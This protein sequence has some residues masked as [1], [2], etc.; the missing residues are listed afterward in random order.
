[1][2]ITNKKFDNLVKAKDTLRNELNNKAGI[3]K[4]INDKNGNYYVGSSNNLYRRLSEHCNLDRTKKLLKKGQSAIGS[5]IMRY[6]PENFSL[7]ILELI[8]LKKADT[9]ED[10]KLKI[11][12]REQFYLDLLNPEYNINLIAGSNLGRVYS[13]EVRSKMSKAKKGLSSHRKGKTHLAESRALMV[14]NNTMKKM[15]HTYDAD[16][17][18]LKSYPSILAAQAAT[19]IP[20]KRIQKSA[21]QT[22]AI[23]LKENIIFSFLKLDTLTDF[24]KLNKNI[25]NKKKLYVYNA[26]GS[27][28]KIFD[29]ITEGV[30]ETNVSAKRI[31]AYAKQLGLIKKP[32]FILDDKFIF[33]FEPLKK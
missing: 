19:G 2:N 20:R 32:Q 11:L 3:Y 17:K 28:F 27:L 21:I 25:S 7:V 16:G 30:K 22:P 13:D 23:L 9:A 12:S 24:I 5:A 6:K 29:S 26:D 8:D 15:V 31:N 18:F 4:L 33:S 10:N 14:M 1:M